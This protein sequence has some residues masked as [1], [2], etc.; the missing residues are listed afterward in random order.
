MDEVLSLGLELFIR[1]P[2]LDLVK[3]EVVSKS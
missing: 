2:F 3:S 1:A